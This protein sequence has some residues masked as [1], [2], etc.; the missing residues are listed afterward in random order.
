MRNYIGSKLD[1]A[2]RYYFKGGGG[3]GSS[4]PPYPVGK[5]KA[6]MDEYIRDTKADIKPL[7]RDIAKLGDKVTKQVDNLVAKG[8]KQLSQEEKELLT[9]LKQH[10]QKLTKF[11]E[12]EDASLLKDLGKINA[13]FQK[14]MNLLDAKDKAE[15]QKELQ[16]FQTKADKL[17]ADFDKRATNVIS[18]GDTES[19]KIL[20]DGDQESKSILDQYEQEGLSL[21]D[22]YLQAVDTARSTFDTDYEASL[23]LSPERL[24][25]FSQAAD[26]LSKSAQQTRLDMIA[27]ADPRAAE[28]SAI[29]D[30]NAAAMM[31]GRISA[32]T[33]ANLARTSAMR[34]L[35]GGFG[36]GSEMG[37]GLTARDLGLSALDLQQQG[38]QNYEAQRRLNFDTRVAG[39]Q[40]D[41]GA[42]L[43]NDMTARQRQAMTNYEVGLRTAES[44]RDQRQGIFNTA[45]AGNLARVDTRVGRDMGR[46]DN[47]VSRQLDVAGNVFNAGFETNRYGFTAQQANRDS[48]TARQANRLT[49]VWDRNFQNRVGMYNTNVGT[50]RSIYGTN[51]NAAGNM[52]NTQA[53]AIQNATAARIGV[54]GDVYGTN[55]GTRLAGFEALTRARTNAAATNTDAVQKNWAA[56]NARWSANQTG[57]NAMWG[58]L[59]QTGATIAGTAIG[60]ATG[61]PLAGY[62]IGSV[63]GSVGNQAVSGGQGGGSGS[64]GSGLNS[65]MGFTSALA[66]QGGAGTTYN[67]FA[68]AQNAAPYTNIFSF[69]KGMG[70]TPVAMRA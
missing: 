17:T 22:R 18:K 42:L 19:S 38:F 26:F 24:A 34:A 8:E 21:G 46:V 3:G 32:D 2:T 1:L 70:Y 6:M 64:I 63:V 65:I 16:G 58:S 47:R 39:L 31:S 20:K 40:A 28:L 48:R 7:I 37:R 53:G 59:L 60:A 27:A 5:I 69:N 67:S 55:A 4:P 54:R 10:E 41:A 33:Q 49:N 50:A 57:N 44:D 36:A 13:D 23:D 56:E 43:T 45:L 35:Q 11:Q 62:Q 15:F 29:A 12:T 14:G 52:F 30:E 66:G 9:S 25:I 61:N 51:V 68:G